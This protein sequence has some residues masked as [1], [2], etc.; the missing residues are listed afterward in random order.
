M[1]LVL[2]DDQARLVEK[3]RGAMRQRH[4]NVLMVSPTGSGKTAMALHMIYGALGKGKKIGF[5]V[6]RKTL[7]QQTSESFAANGIR[8]GWV[9]AGRDFNPFCD[10]YICMLDTMASRVR[11]KA[12]LPKF[13]LLF[14]D[15]AHYGAGGMDEVIAYYK[16]RGTWIV[17]MSATPWKLNGSGLGK[18]YD[19]MVEGESVRWLIDNKRLSDYRYFHGKSVVERDAIP[20]VNG[21]FKKKDAS[22]YM[23]QNDA[24]IGDCVS[25]YISRCMGRLH[26]VRCSSVKHSM[27]TAAAFRDAGVPALHVDGETITSD[28]KKAIMAFA[29]R[30][31]YVLTFCDLLTFGFDLSQASGMDVCIESGSDMRMSMSLAAQMQFWG[32][33]LRYKDYPAIINDHAN[34]WLSHG[35]PSSPRTWSLRDRIQ[36]K[37]GGERAPP[38]KQCPQ[39]GCFAIHPPAPKCPECGYIYPPKDRD[40]KQ[41]DGEMVELDVAAVESGNYGQAKPKTQR[42]DMDDPRAQQRLDYYIRIAVKRGFKNPG[43][44]AAK[45]LGEEFIAMRRQK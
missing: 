7:A 36:K 45:R 22:Q 10:L 5:M 8:H 35:V 21:E 16:A 4:R 14:V 2:F 1:S 40:P 32:R 33:M 41:E 3:V 23:E 43:T 29:R 20:V 9:A 25:D 19:H 12:D 6:P 18:Y 30:E 31:I 28:L 13:D 15:E 37:K 34:N 42:L 27:K 26:V 24:L 38:T 39:E 11:K 17:G 44:W